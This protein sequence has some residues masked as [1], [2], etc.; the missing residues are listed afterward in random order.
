MNFYVPFAE[1]ALEAEMIWAL[2]RDFLADLGLPTTRRRIAA[3]S[4]HPD[5]SNSSSP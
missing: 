1:D 5:V 3:L 2:T 4:L